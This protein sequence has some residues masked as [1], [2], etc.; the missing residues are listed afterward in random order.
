MKTSTTVTPLSKLTNT[1]TNSPVCKHFFP[2]SSLDNNG[3]LVDVKGG[4]IAQP[5]IGKTFIFNSSEKSVIPNCDGTVNPS[6]LSSGSWAVLGTGKSALF[7]CAGYLDSTYVATN[8]TIRCAIGDNNQDLGL[9]SFQGW[10]M[11]DGT[12][13]VYQ[14]VA[15]GGNVYQGDGLTFNGCQSTSGGATGVSITQNTYF[16]R[17]AVYQPGLQHISRI[18]DSNGTVLIDSSTLYNSIADQLGATFVNAFRM[19]GFRC[20]GIAIYYFNSSTVPSDYLTAV[21]YNGA[22]WKKGTREIYPVTGW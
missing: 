10:G 8:K 20:T 12:T 17:Y 3:N 16:I 6:I 5:Q 18:I 15:F 9:S 22:L 11:S 2:C 4:V 7:M 19:H 1:W 14:H 13:S 21:N